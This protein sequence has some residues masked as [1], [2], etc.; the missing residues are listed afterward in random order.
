MQKLPRGNSLSK[1][2]SNLIESQHR[3]DDT[4]QTKTPENNRKI[5]SRPR[6]VTKVKQKM[7]GS[8]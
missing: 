5:P 2:I 7:D 3:I 8:G 1:S 4:R 6:L